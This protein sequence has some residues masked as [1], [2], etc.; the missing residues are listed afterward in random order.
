MTRRMLHAGGRGRLMTE[1]QGSR[2]G[3][4]QAPLTAAQI[5]EEVILGHL[6]L[7]NHLRHQVEGGLTVYLGG[8][9][10]VV[11]EFLGVGDRVVVDLLQDVPEQPRGWP[12]VELQG[13]RGALPLPT[14]TAPV[15]WRQ[16]P[17]RWWVTHL[18]L[19]VSK[20]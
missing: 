19:C 3:G 6:D 16:Y 20:S 2:H 11:V 12:R 10:L 5:H 13:L 17:D 9:G 18:P 1:P 14:Q 4:S 15:T 7:V 8:E